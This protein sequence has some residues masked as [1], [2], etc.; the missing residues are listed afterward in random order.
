MSHTVAVDPNVIKMGHRL[1]I[2]T[3][4]NRKA[5]NSFRTLVDRLWPRGLSKDKAKLDLWQKDIA[6]INS[7]RKWFGHDEKKWGEFRRRYFK[8]LD[9]NNV[10][11]NT[12][13]K[14]AKEGPITLLYDSKEEKINNAVALKEYLEKE[15]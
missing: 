8:E 3:T 6:P 2:P 10:S 7:L 9:N 5:D 11:V 1:I 15:N 4:D 13:L 14:K 12:I